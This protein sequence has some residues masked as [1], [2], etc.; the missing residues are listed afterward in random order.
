MHLPPYYDQ[1]WLGHNVAPYDH[2]NTGLLGVMLRSIKDFY[3]SNLTPIGLGGMVAYG[4]TA[5]FLNAT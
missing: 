5:L 3:L 2:S 4:P 1:G